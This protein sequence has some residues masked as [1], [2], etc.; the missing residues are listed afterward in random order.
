MRDQVF[1]LGFVS[2]RLFETSFPRIRA[3]GKFCKQRPLGAIGGGVIVL[4]CLM[5]ILADVITPFNPLV[6]DYDAI[7]QPPTLNHWMGTDAF[8]RDIFSRIIYG[9]RTALLVGFSTSF[10][11]AT[12]GALIG[13]ACAYFGGLFDLLVQRVVEIFISFPLIILALAVI[14][15]LGAGT[16]NVIIAVCLPLVPRCAVVIRSKAVSIREMPYI[17]AARACGFGHL[18]IITKH[19]LPN[20]MAPYLILLTASLGGAILAEA[21]LSY[22]GMGVA[23]PTPAWGL[24]LKGGAVDFAEAPLGWPSSLD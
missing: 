21:S 12:L 15:V 1:Q 7:L 9:S 16:L 8:G 14:A 23:E 2:R 20:V 24:M 19:M 3:V 13:V 18:R 10:L 5:A 4:M 17:D 6:N 11:G 22:L